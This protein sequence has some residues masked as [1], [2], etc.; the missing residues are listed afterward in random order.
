MQL[1]E[2]LREIAGVGP[3]SKS[4]TA[5]VTA[6]VE[7]FGPELSISARCRSPTWGGASSIAAEAIG[8]LRAATSAA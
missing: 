3:K 1:L 4:V 5:Q 8:L 6:L 7:R 2:I